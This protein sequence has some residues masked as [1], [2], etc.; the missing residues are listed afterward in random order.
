MKI[1]VTGG[2]GFIGSHL[3]RCLLKSGL[4]IVCIDNFDGFYPRAIKEN[5]IKNLINNK[6]FKLIEG[7]IQDKYLVENMIGRNNIEIVVH[8]AAKAGVRPSIVDPIEYYKTNVIGTINL[9]EAMKM[10]GCKKM[11]F[12]SSSSV[13]G[14]NKNV[15]FSENDSVDNPISPYAATK[16]AGELLCHTYHYLYGF[17]IFCLRF[18]T[19]YGPGQRPDLAIHKFA[20]LIMEGKPIPFYGDGSTERDYTYIDDIIDGI[21]KAINNLKGYNIFNL[22]ESNSISLAKM[23]ATLEN[24]IGKTAIL[25]KLP[26]QLGDVEKTFADISKARNELGYN[27]KYAF[28][29]G[30]SNFIEWLLKNK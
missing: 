5:N 13:Y 29:E 2:A 9:L 30:I 11:I 19:V 12:A 6:R 25:E 18:F 26:M 27:P 16:K 24:T 10:Y 21:I 22:G 20:R 15:P 14:N 1:V 7:D 28:E 8:L 17:D 4:S 23:V 3:I